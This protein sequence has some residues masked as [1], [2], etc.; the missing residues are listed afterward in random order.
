[1]HIEH[2]FITPLAIDDLDLDNSMLE[3]F[4]KDQIA[5]SP[6][7]QFNQTP[8]LDLD[9]PELADLV[10]SIQDKVNNFHSALGLSD[11]FF[12]SINNAWANINNNPAITSA[13]AHYESA[14]SGVYYVKADSTSATLNFLSPVI[15]QNHVIFPKHVAEWNKFTNQQPA[16][17]PKPGRLLI[18]PA[19]ISHFVNFQGNNSERISIAF[20]T[21]LTD[22]FNFKKEI[23]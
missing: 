3:K 20:N 11:R 22:K 17:V 6:H 19:W 5:N 12:Q 8:N 23:L 14:F 18:W 1:M 2:L 15:S 7:N 10:C 9:A 16:Y 13:H 21:V 4:C